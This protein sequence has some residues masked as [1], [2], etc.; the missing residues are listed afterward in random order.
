MPRPLQRHALQTLARTNAALRPVVMEALAAYLGAPAADGGFECTLPDGAGAV[1][2][3]VKPAAGGGI[4]AEVRDANTG[5][6]FGTWQV[7]LRAL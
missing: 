7:M 4:F 1:R 6:H 5:G 3:Y 2:V